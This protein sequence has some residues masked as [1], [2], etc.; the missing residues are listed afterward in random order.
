MENA[1]ALD[2]STIV[3][4]QRHIDACNQAV[5]VAWLGQISDRASPQYASLQS[6]VGKTGHEY[7]RHAMTIGDQTVLQLHAVQAWHLDIGDQ[8]DRG[9]QIGGFEEFLSRTE[10]HGLIAERSDKRLCGFT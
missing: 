9:F 6:F 3:V 5:L 2:A 1:L 8:A 4:R 7:H 10:C